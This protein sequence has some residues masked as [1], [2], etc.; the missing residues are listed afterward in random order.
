MM[1]PH[2]PLIITLFVLFCWHCGRASDPVSKSVQH[3]FSDAEIV[4]TAGVLSDPGERPIRSILTYP[5]Q[6]A[7]WSVN[8]QGK[9]ALRF[10]STVQGNLRGSFYLFRD[11]GSRDFTLNLS[12]WLDMEQP[13]AWSGILFWMKNHIREALGVR[14]KASGI[15]RRLQVEFFQYRQPELSTIVRQSFSIDESRWADVMLKVNGQNLTVQLD[16]HQ[17]LQAQLQEAWYLGNFI[18][19][20]QGYGTGHLADLKVLAGEQELDY[21]NLLAQWNQEMVN[22]TRKIMFEHLAVP[23]D[24]VGL[25]I[26]V[27][28][29]ALAQ[30]WR[31]CVPVHGDSAVSFRVQVPKD[32]TLHLGHGI[33]PPFALSD[34]RI[35]FEVSV[36]K[37]GEQVE[38]LYRKTLHPRQDDVSAFRFHDLHVALD[39]FAGEEVEL[40]LSTRK[41]GEEP[42]LGCWSEPILS[43]PKLKDQPNVVL[44]VLDTLRADRVGERTDTASLTPNIDRISGQGVNF[45]NTIAQA[46][47][48]TPSHAS[49][50]TSLYPSETG[51]GNP[52]NRGNLLQEGYLTWAEIFQRQGYHTAAFTNGIQ[53][54]GELGFHQGFDRYADIEYDKAYSLETIHER[55]REFLDSH[56]DEP[57]FLFLHT[58]AVHFPYEHEQYLNYRVIPRSWD[59]QIT[60][61]NHAYDGGVRFADEWVWDIYTE[62]EERGTLDSTLLII[63]SDHGEELGERGMPRPAR[64]GMTLYDEVLKVPLILHYPK[65]GHRGKSITSQVRLLDVLPTVLDIMNW[66]TPPWCHGISL[67]SLLNGGESSERVALSEGLTYGVGQVSLRTERYKLI[68]VPDPA[69]ELDTPPL[70]IPIEP[71]EPVQLHDLKNDP[72]E[73]V[74][75]AQQNPDKTEEL[76]RVLQLIEQRKFMPEFFTQGQTQVMPEFSATLMEE[77]QAMGYISN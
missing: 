33:L 70:K 36:G 62:L 34:T 44:I 9:P 76:Q 8:W 25:K 53:V 38:E 57:Y 65:L 15:D 74:N 19:F 5:H 32:A 17:P 58:Y 71:P 75:I 56:D 23:D 6:D 46:S 55:L 54:R 66:E 68:H 45:T 47:W 43:T 7:L 14:W 50:F 31:A 11:I 27:R 72:D 13:E 30:E 42:I 48:T 4:S 51:C 18:G 37:D 39:R 24:M 1:K 77:L 49:L 52:S 26:P 61:D 59:D 41:E 12:S 35:T 63:T 67:L 22:T 73:T 21:Q 60:I 10:E 69:N 2:V 3:L 64:H 16:E 28:R 40:V 29:I 20:Y